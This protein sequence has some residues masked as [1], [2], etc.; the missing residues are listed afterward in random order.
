RSVR[1]LATTRA[2][3]GF[4]VGDARLKLKDAPDHSYRLIVVDAFSS[5]A[6]PIHLITKEAVELYFDKLTD[7]GI[8]CIHISNRYLELGP[9]LGNI[10][11]E[12]D[13]KA[14]QQY[15]NETRIGA[16]MF[17]G[18][19]S[20]DWVMLAKKQ[21]TLD[22]LQWYNSF[23]SVPG[24]MDFPERLR[25]DGWKGRADRAQAYQN[26]LQL[27]ALGAMLG[28]NALQFAADESHWNPQAPEPTQSTWTDDYSNIISIFRW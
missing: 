5:D 4:A 12:L 11:K 25:E 22:E 7:D 28:A 27:N 18:K 2:V 13:L 19:N 3:H 17:P 1:G 10:A 20:S 14:I 16:R 23:N 21:N 24:L 26:T 6:I 15:D 9:V 8:A